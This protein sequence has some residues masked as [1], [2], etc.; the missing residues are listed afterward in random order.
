ME[1][2]D[3]VSQI[4]LDIVLLRS[5]E[6]PSEAEASQNAY[7]NHLRAKDLKELYSNYNAIADQ[8]RAY[9]GLQYRYLVEL[10]DA[11]SGLDELNF[12]GSFTW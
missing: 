8:I 6:V 1:V 10:E 5:Y 11:F 7:D 2:V 3:D 9:P 12:D 4:V